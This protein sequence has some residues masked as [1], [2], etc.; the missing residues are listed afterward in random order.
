MKMYCMNKQARFCIRAVLLR[1]EGPLKGETVVRDLFTRERHFVQCSS[2]H[3][4]S[5]DY[6]KRLK[7]LNLGSHSF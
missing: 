2:D 3:E 6:P 7:P 5:F 1:L 4:D